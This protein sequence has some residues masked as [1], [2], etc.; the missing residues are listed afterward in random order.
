MEEEILKLVGY[1]KWTG[2]QLFKAT[3]QEQKSHH[4]NKTRE[5]FSPQQLCREDNKEPVISTDFLFECPRLFTT[6]A[7]KT[8]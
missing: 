3:V 1:N 5:S 7:M 4:V 2:E 8:Q 6:G